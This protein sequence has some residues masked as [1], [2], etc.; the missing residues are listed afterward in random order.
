MIFYRTKAI[1]LAET[2]PKFPLRQFFSAN[3]RFIG[4][5]ANSFWQYSKQSFRKFYKLVK[6]RHLVYFNTGLVQNLGHINVFLDLWAQLLQ[7]NLGTCQL[8]IKLE[9][10][11]ESAT[12]IFE[13]FAD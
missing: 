12:K 4:A 5:R 2:G 8:A 11:H 10:T 7:D 1:T 3:Q 6:I 13:S 9:G